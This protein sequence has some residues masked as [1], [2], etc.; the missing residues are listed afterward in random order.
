MH[1]R[2]PRYT[3]GGHKEFPPVELQ[4]ADPRTLTLDAC[5]AVVCTLQAL[6]AAAADGLDPADTLLAPVVITASPVGPDLWQSPATIDSI[7]GEVLREGQMQIHL[8]E[9]LARVPGL[10]V[11]N[12]QNLAQ[13]LQI[14]V[15]GFGAR[16]T[17][18]VRGLRLYVDGIPA[19]APDGQGQ[20]ANFPIGNAARIDVVRGP[21]AVL[22]GNSAGGALLLYT[23]DG[24][25]PGL[26]R[27]GAALGSDGLWR[28]S[29][30][31]QGRV[32]GRPD[33][34]GYALHVERF[35]TDGQRPQSAADRNTLHLK[36]SRQTDDHRLLLQYQQ[37]QT[38]ALDPLGLTRAEFDADPAQTT[39]NAV[40]FNTWKSVRQ[41]QMG[42]AWQYR[43]DAQQR[44]ELMVY[45][46]A[47][48]VVQ[49]QAIPAATQA[50]PS[51]AGGVIDLDRDYAGLNLRWR[52]TQDGVAGG[53]LAWSVGLAHD[54]QG[55]WRRGFQNFVGATLGVQGALRRQERNQATT[56]DPY[57]QAEWTRRDL[58]LSAGLRHTRVRYQSVDHYLAPGN[59]DDSGAMGWRGWLPMLGLR[60]A[61]S[62]E[63]QGYV[64]IGRGI[65]TPTLN[66]VA[67]RP[68]GQG[69]LNTALAASAHETLEVGLR[70]RHGHAGWTLA[71][72]ET[73]T[74]RELT[75]LSNTGGRATFQNAG[76]T[77]RSG[78]ELSADAQWGALSVSGALTLLN[79]RYR[80]GFLACDSTPCAAPAAPVAPGARLPGVAPR[81]AWAE[82]AWQVAPAW[83]WTVDLLHSGAVPV[84]DLNTDRSA[85]YTVW[86]SSLRWTR[87]WQDWRAQAFLRWDNLQDRR[88]AGSVI[89]N[90][91]N[92]RYFEPGAGRSMSAGLT[93]SRAF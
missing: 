68:G 38:D 7:D 78:L 37:Q 20:A 22:Y 49:F 10:V 69:G 74:A 85:A 54:W 53:R 26:W 57:V 70:G 17:F 80:D 8:S 35:A 9:G 64:S 13:D 12:R 86:G 29:T 32:G 6:T 44:M 71:V 42:L 5:A 30:Q 27:S 4:M 11:Q 1:A 46:G 45:G 61:L 50:P 52:R 65:E 18:G 16:S 36:L 72:F 43:M 73:R 47:R 83:V 93:L 55:E 25:V 66:E 60:L 90:E 63:L 31:L 58:S 51:H 88:Y 23:E 82:L 3:L 76:R 21:A 62:P 19:S 91:G 14:S 75:V 92:R 59:P 39:A 34:W 2:Q 87:R 56:T 28:L 24:D 41:N 81:R 40:R 48:S 33:G 15:R 67:Y 84:S 79:A 77:R 89:V